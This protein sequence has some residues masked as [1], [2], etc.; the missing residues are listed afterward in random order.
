ME[1]MTLDNDV[2]NEDMRRNWTTFAS[3]LPAILGLLGFEGAVLGQEWAASLLQHAAAPAA[4]AWGYT[5]RRPLLAT[6]FA[7]VLGAMHGVE[8][9]WQEREDIMHAYGIRDADA[10]E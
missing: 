5:F 4:V 2:T 6:L 3:W 8:R 10:A 1:P 7:A 9:F